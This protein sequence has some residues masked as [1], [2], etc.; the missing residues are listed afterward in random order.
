[1]WWQDDYIG[2]FIMEKTLTLNTDLP[3]LLSADLQ[4]ALPVIM[5]LYLASL[6]IKALISQ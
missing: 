4:D 1:M 6:L 2:A 5:V 3:P